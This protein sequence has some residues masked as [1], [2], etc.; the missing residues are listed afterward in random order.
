MWTRGVSKSLTYSEPLK[1]LHALRSLKKTCENAGLRKIGWHTLRH[2]FAS[3]LAVNSVPMKAVQELLGHANIVTTMRY[4]HVSHATLRDAVKTLDER[5][6]GHNMV[7]MPI[8][9]PQN[10][11]EFTDKNGGILA[12]TRLN[13]VRTA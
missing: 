6:F 5:N 11:D 8:D 9:V 3:H 1:S 4:S 10:T 2:T 12:K 7:T 13:L